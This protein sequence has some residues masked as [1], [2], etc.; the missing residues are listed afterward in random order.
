M[1]QIFLYGVAYVREFSWFNKFS[2]N[3]VI[4]SAF[5]NE[6]FT[7]SALGF[8]LKI[9]LETIYLD[10]ALKK[11]ERLCCCDE[12]FRCVKGKSCSFKRVPTVWLENRILLKSYQI[13]TILR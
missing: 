9:P 3:V 5:L 6:V 8:L 10:R 2:G 11:S 1:Q 12:H 7:L 13:F 4:L